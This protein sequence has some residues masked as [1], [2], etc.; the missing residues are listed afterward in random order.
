M[1]TKN[2][3]VVA[4]IL[5][6]GRAIANEAQKLLMNLTPDKQAYALAHPVETSD[7]HCPA[8]NWA[9]YRGS[10]KKGNAF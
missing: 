6:P 3:W 2:I 8:G 9:F 5:F 10:D 4:L 7:Q 1:N